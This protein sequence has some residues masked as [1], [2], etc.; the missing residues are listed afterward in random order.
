MNHLAHGL[1]VINAVVEE[2]GVPLNL[3]IR[4]VIDK[5]GL[6]KPETFR[7]PFRQLWHL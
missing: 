5:A 3:V 1:D 4:V 7:L 6:V 2:D